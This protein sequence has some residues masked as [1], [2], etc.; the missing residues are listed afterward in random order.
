MTRKYRQRGYMDGNADED[1]DKPRPAPRKP[2]TEEE[3]IQRKSM[4]HAIDRDAREVLRC[5]VCGR[6]I[7]DFGTIGA[8]SACPFCR[9]ALRCCRTCANF[10]SAARWQCRAPIEA[11][12]SDKSLANDCPSY[13]PRLVLDVT[14]R[15][16]A[17][18]GQGKSGDPR[19]QFENLFKR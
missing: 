11:A 19:S 18:G 7:A 2:L 4:R 10:D 3:R 9:A 6:G 13:A 12:V 5:H 15:R 14:G 17:P 8:D 16:S 1:R